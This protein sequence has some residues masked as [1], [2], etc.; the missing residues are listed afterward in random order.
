MVRESYSLILF[1]D[2]RVYFV[3]LWNNNGMIVEKKRSSKLS[4]RVCVNKNEIIMGTKMEFGRLL[5]K[6]Q[7]YF[8]RTIL[9]K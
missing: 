8:D 1:L 3:G 6:Y 9:K 7:E 2:N 5:V 4:I